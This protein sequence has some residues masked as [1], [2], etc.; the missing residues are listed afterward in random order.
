MK[1]ASERRQCLLSRLTVE[2][3]EGLE[4]TQRVPLCVRQPSP[5]PPTHIIV[6]FKKFS[7][8]KIFCPGFASLVYFKVAINRLLSENLPLALVGGVSLVSRDKTRAVSRQKPCSSPLILSEKFFPII[9]ENFDLRQV[10][11]AILL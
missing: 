7:C 11:R 8:L 6:K 4:T 9:L 2:W 10:C 1:M 5:H 3:G